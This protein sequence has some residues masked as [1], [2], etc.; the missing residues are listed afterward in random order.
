MKTPAYYLVAAL[1]ASATLVAGADEP[2]SL[3]PP[4]HVGDPRPEHAVTNGECRTSFAR[5]A[6]RSTQRASSRPRLRHLRGR[7]AIR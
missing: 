1:L 4:K 5:L 3:V 2:V 7:P 6:G